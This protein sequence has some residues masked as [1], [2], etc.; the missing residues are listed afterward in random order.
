[1]KLV[2]CRLQDKDFILAPIDKGEPPSWVPAY[3]D[4]EVIWVNREV[5]DKVK[6]QRW[7]KPCSIC[8]QEVKES[9]AKRYHNKSS[10]ANETKSQ[11]E[12]G[13]KK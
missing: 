5:F 8:P 6:A 2:K 4:E 7:F 10:V 9:C 11:E 13:K 1:L 3:N 12:M